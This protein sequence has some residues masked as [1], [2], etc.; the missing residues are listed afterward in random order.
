MMAKIVTVPGD[1]LDDR[2]Q[3]AAG[4]VVLAFYQASCAPCRALEPRLERMAATYSGRVAVYRIDI[5]RDLPVAEHF[6]V[7]SIPTLL[8]VHGGQAIERLDGLIREQDLTAH[9]Q[10]LAETPSV[11]HEQRPG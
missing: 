3:R 7:M 9:F 1:E 4:P 5:D 8:V 2:V 11:E 6:G 10:R